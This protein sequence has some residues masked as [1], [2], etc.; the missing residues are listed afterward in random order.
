MHLDAAT[1]RNVNSVTC[2]TLPMSRG[3]WSQLALFVSGVRDWHR[4]IL[5]V[6]EESRTEK[7]DLPQI[8]NAQ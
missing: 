4:I 3:D 6:L 5:P 8:G 7:A 2:L 1:M